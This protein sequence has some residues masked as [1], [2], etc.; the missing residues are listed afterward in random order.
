M[1]KVLKV[2][3]KDF[4]IFKGECIFDFEN[5]QKQ[6]FD[7]ICIYGQNGLG[8]TSF[9]DGIEWYVDG[10]I[11]R[12][13]NI[14]K[15]QK[16]SFNKTIL[17]NKYSSN[18]NAS[19]SLTLTNGK[20]IKRTTVNGKNSGDY[21]KGRLSPQK[22]QIYIERNCILPNDR[23]ANFISASKPTERYTE[24]GSF[25]NDGVNQQE[26]LNS[27]YLVKRKLQLLLEDTEKK[28]CKSKEDLSKLDIGN[29]VKDE[30][31]Q[32]ILKYQLLNKEKQNFISIIERQESGK[33]NLPDVV[34]LNDEKNNNNNL[35]E[36]LEKRLVKFE[37]LHREY[38]A[39][40]EKLIQYNSAIE[41]K[42]IYEKY[43]NQIKF[44][45]QLEAELLRI[46]REENIIK[47][48]I[49]EELNKDLDKYRKIYNS[50]LEKKEKINEIK[51]SYLNE[52]KISKSKQHELIQKMKN[53]ETDFL[54][55]TNENKKIDDEIKLIKSL[56]IDSNTKLDFQLDL[57]SVSYIQKDVN[58]FNLNKQVL[59]SQL[60]IKNEIDHNKSLKQ[61]YDSE[62][63]N[64]DEVVEAVNKIIIHIKMNNMSECPV[65]KTLF[66]STEDLISKFDIS[67]KEKQLNKIYSNWIDSSN[68]LKIL[69][70]DTIEC[71]KNWNERCKNILQCKLKDYTS[72]E[73]TISQ[74]N[75]DK[76]DIQNDIKDVLELIE[77]K[78]I[79][80]NELHVFENECT[81]DNCIEW[82]RNCIEEKNR[83]IMDVEITIEKIRK[84]KSE[85]KESLDNLEV[86]VNDAFKNNLVEFQNNEKIYQIITLQKNREEKKI[87][88][89][90]LL[91]VKKEELS[92][93]TE[94]VNK[95][96][97]YIERNKNDIDEFKNLYIDQIDT[98]SIEFRKIN[99]GK[100]ELEG[101]IGIYKECNMLLDKIV[102]RIS[103]ANYN[104][105]FDSRYSEIVEL[106]KEI[107]RYSR[108]LN[109]FEQ[110]YEQMKKE[111]ENNINKMFGNESM[112][113]IYKRIEPYK[114][115]DKLDYEIKFNDDDKPELYVK[116]KNSKSGE[117]I[118]PE[119]F[120]STAQLNIVALS[121]F[122]GKAISRID[123]EVKTIFIDDPIVSLD[124]LN[125]LAFV[126]LIRTI[127]EKGEW[128][129]IIST[130]NEALFRLFQRKI[131]S[132][133]YNSKFIKFVG[134][135]MIER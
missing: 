118:L 132:E 72:N 46:N 67:D 55:I 14:Q 97:A 128:Q 122:L 77:L 5:S 113:M 70:E 80:L 135:G 110:I 95:N 124:D 8:K 53:K 47:L 40:Q 64:F 60:K 96:S 21:S 63:A 129:I 104:E 107:E 38:E 93:Y 119:L 123:A 90:K 85:V 12:I 66:Q 7:L 39:F 134:K 100:L 28:L 121:V 18:K 75:K 82:F 6:P 81:V 65:C 41:N 92:F 102:T 37:K 34:K 76:N 58:L 43:I 111:L 9:F 115:F 59:N 26:I 35:I 112:N 30:I 4:R 1:N 23:I 68:K 84:F 117:E 11:N 25:L 133:Y 127:I 61:R 24:W 108:G 73:N 88:L 78:K 87:Q 83:I 52:I 31:N 16:G 105:I 29:E 15:L 57:A 10:K 27:V 120:Y 32:Y 109:E 106:E 51:D 71:I 79:E 3:L 69:Q 13:E 99:N 36:Q 19:V 49:E 62:K 56:I 101:L 125:A 126:D 130:H 54:K 45:E 86:I 114:S 2:N 91:S 48:K 50:E 22:S 98:E 116:G 44:K 20:T 94:M 74:L 131:S 33:L 103:I 89:E 17:K 42:Q